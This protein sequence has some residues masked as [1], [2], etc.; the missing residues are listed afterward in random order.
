MH[1]GS[2]DAHQ[3]AT[4]FKAGEPDAVRIVQRRVRRVLSFKGYGIPADDRSDLEQEVMAQLWQAAGRASFRPDSG[5]WGFVNVVVGRRCIDWLR[6]RKRTVELPELECRA[7]SV[8]LARLL[9]EE[10]RE[11]AYAALAKLGKPCRD[12]VYLRAV[13]GLDYHEMSE[14][15]G[16]S[17]GALRVLLHRCV[18]RARQSLLELADGNSPRGR[19]RGEP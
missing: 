18:K 1:A 17:Q 2:S 8:P 13:L 4:R 7:S 12:A 11:L 16:K 5:F 3:I 10:R 19:R 6:T 9:T 14:V 15:L